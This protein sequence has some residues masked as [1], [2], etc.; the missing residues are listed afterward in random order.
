MLIVYLYANW[1]VFIM[2]IYADNGMFVK[3]YVFLDRYINIVCSGF[4][5]FFER[6]MIF[7]RNSWNLLS[8]YISNAIDIFLFKFVFY[9]I[10]YIKLLLLQ[11]VGG[12][13]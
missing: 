5:F 10:S 1:V 3:Y 9:I 12:I 8:Y 11:R 7:I 2:C 13:N 6:Y 4:F